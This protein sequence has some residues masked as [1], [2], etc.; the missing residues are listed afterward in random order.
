[1][2][3]VPEW[4][5]QFVA[6]VVGQL[7]REID[8]ET[9]M[10]WIQ[11]TGALREALE[12]LAAAGTRALSLKTD[13]AMDGW[14]LVKDATEPADVSA[15]TMQLGDFLKEGEQDLFGEDAVARRDELTGLLGQRH[16]EYLV[17]HPDQIPEEY[18][19][20]SLVFA[21][22]VWASPDGNHQIPCL[23]WA[24]EHWEMIFGILEGGLETRDKL[25]QVKG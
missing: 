6:E 21:G 5:T 24:K 17:A 1:M 18:R 2:A 23:T 9:A 11:D 3:E 12:V 22:T 15:E 20:F 10:G 13:K 4:Y 19:K 7:P 16:A 25:V 8:E 14:E